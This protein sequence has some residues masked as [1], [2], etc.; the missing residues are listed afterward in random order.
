MSVYHFCVEKFE[1]DAFS[2]THILTSTF[3]LELFF[4][5]KKVFYCCKKCLETPLIDLKRILAQRK[6]SEFLLLLTQYI[7]QNRGISDHFFSHRAF[8]RGLGFAFNEGIT[9]ILCNIY[10][11][12]AYPI[13]SKFHM[14]SYPSFVLIILSKFHVW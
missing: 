7:Q 3:S 12:S 6:N 9:I 1:R 14:V 11:N 5:K 10:S 2:F 13:L 8:S 4:L